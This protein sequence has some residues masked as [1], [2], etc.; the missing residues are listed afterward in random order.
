MSDFV[1]MEAKGFGE[2]LT[3]NE[4]VGMLGSE[5]VEEKL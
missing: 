5:L 2:V 3:L 1:N 4:L